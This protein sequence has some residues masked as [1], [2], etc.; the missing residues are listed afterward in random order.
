MLSFVHV[1]VQTSH[2][3]AFEM[4][5]VSTIDAAIDKFKREPIPPEMQATAS[6]HAAPYQPYPAVGSRAVLGDPQAS[7]PAAAGAAAPHVGAAYTAGAYANGQY[8]A[9]PQQQYQQPYSVAAT[10]AAVPGKTCLLPQAHA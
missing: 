9:Y 3:P 8:G 10:A 2:M 1:L 7:Y 6:H 4:Q 5:V